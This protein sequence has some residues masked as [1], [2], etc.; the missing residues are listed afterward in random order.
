MDDGTRKDVIE[1]I[2]RY[3]DEKEIADIDANPAVYLRRTMETKPV[4]RAIFYYRC[5]RCC[6]ENRRFQH[7]VITC[8][9]FLPKDMRIE[10]NSGR[11]G[12]G[13]RIWHGPVVIGADAVLGENVSLGP[14]VVVGKHHC[15]S[16]VIHDNVRINANS[17]VAGGIEIG[18]NAI[19]G[20]GS[21]V[22]S[23][24]PANSV[25]A[26]NPARFLH[27]RKGKES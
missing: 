1:D 9:A 13:L 24:V 14:G 10:I 6:L 21:V 23:D 25:F 19:I 26:G 11:I 22:I 12:G 15:K 7:L 27:H 3:V 4:F 2:K 8:E 20:A 17:I 16:P 5:S 18:E